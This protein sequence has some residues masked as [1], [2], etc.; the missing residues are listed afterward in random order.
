MTLANGLGLDLAGPQAVLV[1]ER[2]ERAAHE[3]RRELEGRRL[4][5][6][7]DDERRRAHRWWPLALKGG[8]VRERSAVRNLAPAGVS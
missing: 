7:V 3:E 4:L 8:N 6:C 1:E 5:R 2:L